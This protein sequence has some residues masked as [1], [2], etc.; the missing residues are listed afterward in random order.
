M[1]TFDLFV[2]EIDKPIEDTMTTKGG[3]K[4]YVDNR[5]KEFEHRVNE[6]PVVC[7][8]FKYDTGVKEGDTLYFHHHVVINGGQ[9][10]TGHENHYLIRWN[11]ESTVGNQAIAYKKK[12]SDEVIP[13]GGWAILE[14]IEKE[15]KKEEDDKSKIVL[16]ELKEK[17]TTTARVAFDSPGM[18]D[19]GLKVGDV[20]GFKKGIDYRFKINGKEYIRI[21][22]DYLDYIEV[23]D[24]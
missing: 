11:A 3:L 5:F 14:D 1:R 4:L 17:P 7:T 24:C 10:L 16:V 2:V 21:P 19:L 15:K 6:A 23:Q 13:L 18:Q 8:P 20:V 12:D 22:Q 9:P